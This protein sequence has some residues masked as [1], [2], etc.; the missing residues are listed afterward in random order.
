[1]TNKKILII[2]DDETFSEILYEYFLLKGFE[3]IVANDGDM[4][5]ELYASFVP[6]LILLDVIL[7]GMNGI[8]VAKTIRL[9][10]KITPI[11]FM[12]GSENTDED[13]ILSFSSGGNDHLKKGF[14]LDF[15]YYKITDRLNSQIIPDNI[16]QIRLGNNILTI[17]N[18]ILSY[19]NQDIEII[20]REEQL[21]K[22]LFKNPNQIIN[23]EKL[24]KSIW[25]CWSENN[26]CMLSNYIKTIKY[27]LAPLK[28]YFYI[29]TYYGIGYMLLVKIK[30]K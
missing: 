17:N 8:E 27:K 15:L 10:D 22:I 9:K 2:E 23:R 19:K 7:P 3:T 20:D 25:K 26:N 12:S 4:G 30:E 13:Q 14:H 18:S 24:V 29:K 21:L 6:D 28:K 1:M 11:F 16:F 5:V